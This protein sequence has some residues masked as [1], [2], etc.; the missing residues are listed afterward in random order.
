MEKETDFIIS[1][2][3]EDEIEYINTLPG[4]LKGFVASC[5][6]GSAFGK[7]LS[8]KQIAEKAELWKQDAQAHLKKSKS[9]KRSVASEQIFQNFIDTSPLL[10]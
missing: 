1:T 3:E 8:E 6:D 10:K 9:R 2:K 5:R 7:V 4:K